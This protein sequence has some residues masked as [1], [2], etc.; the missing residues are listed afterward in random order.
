MHGKVQMDRY[1]WTCPA[2]REVTS[3]ALE[4]WNH[5]VFWLIA[6]KMPLFIDSLKKTARNSDN[7][8]A[9]YLTSRSE[10][11][12]VYSS[13]L[14]NTRLSLN[15]IIILFAVVILCVILYTCLL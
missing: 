6:G 3:S 8:S 2:D 4:R 15:T 7:S 10:L 14:D 1:R 12:P 5:D 9:Y 13:C 11:G